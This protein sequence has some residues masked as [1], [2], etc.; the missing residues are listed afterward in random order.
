MPFLEILK[1]VPIRGIILE[2]SIPIK[3]FEASNPM[4]YNDFLELMKEENHPRIKISFS[5]KQLESALRDLSEPCPD[6]SI[7]IAGITKTYNVQCVIVKCSDNLYLKGKENIK[8]S[9]FKLKPPSRLLG[10]VKVNNEIDVN[11][12]F[13]ITFTDNNSFSATL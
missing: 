3:D 12:G 11:F 8:L 7:T 4:M 10:M 1:I 13:I 2:I 9:D 5:R 6:I